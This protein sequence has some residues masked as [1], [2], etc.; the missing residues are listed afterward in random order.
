M[1][2]MASCISREML[3]KDTQVL[4]NVNMNQY[5]IILGEF[6]TSLFS[7]IVGIIGS[8]KQ[9][10]AVARDQVLPLPHHLRKVLQKPMIPLLRSFSHIYWLRLSYF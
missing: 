5:I 8:A 7:A 3:Y 2:T 9:L 1:I 4:Q 10:Q 6:S